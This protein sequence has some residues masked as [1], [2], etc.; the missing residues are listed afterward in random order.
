M[1]RTAT[2]LL[3]AGLA[4]M[5]LLAGCSRTEEYVEVAQAQQKA[6]QEVTGILKKIENEMDMAAAKDE[7]D[8]RFA[9][10][11]T[12]ARKARELPKPPPPDVEQKLDLAA[13]KR[14]VDDMTYQIGRV[15]ELPGGKEFFQRFEGRTELFSRTVD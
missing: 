3:V 11:D 15:K 2:G 7:L 13:F 9:R 4:T 5:M 14:A 8:E 6:M 10:Y 1:S 12:I